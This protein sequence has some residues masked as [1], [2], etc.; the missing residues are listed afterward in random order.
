[1]SSAAQSA[2]LRPYLSGTLFGLWAAA[3]AL[4]PSLP[5]KPCSPRQRRCCPSRGGRCSVRRDGSRCSSRQRCCCRRCPSRSAI[6]GRT[7]ACSLPALGLLAGVLWGGE[8][9]MVR[10]VGAALSRS[11]A[12]C[13]RVSRRPRGTRVVWRRPAAWRVSGCSG[14]LS[15]CTCLWRTAAAPPRRATPSCTGSAIG[16]A[17]FACVDFYFQFP[18]PA[19]YGPQFVWLDSGVYRRAQGFFYEASTLGQLLR[20]LPGDDRGGV[21]RPRERIAGLAQ[22]ARR[23]AARSSSPPWCSPIRAPR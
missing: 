14:F 16:S 11:S 19:G 7:S 8:W 18:A 10:G 12:C 22:R 4:A 17:L 13:W 9:R 1:M 15:I 23:W 20:V 6:P 5:P 2:R 3:I 21:L